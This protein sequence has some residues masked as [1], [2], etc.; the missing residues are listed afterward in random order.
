[1]VDREKIIKA[2]ETCFDS[3]IDKHR[4]MG[5]DLQAVEQMK[6]DALELLKEQKSEWLEDSDPGQEY[7]TTWACAEC[8]C[9]IHEHTVWNPYRAGFK[10]CPF[11][12]DR[13]V[14][15]RDNQS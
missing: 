13:M 14:L 15:K 11:C 1:M 6:H 10:Y 7:G 8:G 9:S 12:G 2:V 5:L 4:N 3:W